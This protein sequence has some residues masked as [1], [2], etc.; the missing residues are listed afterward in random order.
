M[1]TPEAILFVERPAVAPA[2]RF[3]AMMMIL[4]AGNHG[5]GDGWTVEVT[6]VV[7][8]RDGGQRESDIE[9]SVASCRAEPCRD[10]VLRTMPGIC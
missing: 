6:K 8:M 1:L 3:G 2:L 5:D 9:V 4:G 10:P 7:M